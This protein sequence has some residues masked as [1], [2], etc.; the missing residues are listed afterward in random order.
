MEIKIRD[1][2]ENDLKEATE[3]VLRLKKFNSE[4]DPLFALTEDLENVVM[5]YL[6][7]SIRLKQG[8]FS[9]QKRVERLLELFLQRLL[10][11][12]FTSQKGR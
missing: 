8:M 6:K 7:E 12:I 11:G 9:L 2:E 3:L 10:T 1:L 4:H 5:N